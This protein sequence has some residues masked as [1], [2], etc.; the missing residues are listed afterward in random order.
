[1]NLYQEASHKSKWIKFLIIS[2]ISIKIFSSRVK[3]RSMS[4]AS[5]T[6]QFRSFPCKR[7]RLVLRRLKLVKEVSEQNVKLVSNLI[8]GLSLMVKITE[9]Q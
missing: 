6:I 2:V 9:Q 5:R 1:M 3:I 4:S 8:W 7:C